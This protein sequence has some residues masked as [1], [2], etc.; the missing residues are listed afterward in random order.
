MTRLV[1]SLVCFFFLVP[2]LPAQNWHLAWSDEFNGPANS[3]PSTDDWI[4]GRG[5]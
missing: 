1:A 3:L 4:F 5:G 2:V